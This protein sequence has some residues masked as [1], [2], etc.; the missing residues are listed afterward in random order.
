MA[1]KDDTEPKGKKEKKEKK[2]KK[3]GKSGAKGKATRGDEAVPYS[4]IATHPRARVSVRRAKA[5]TGLIAFGVA[6][7]LSLEASVPVVQAGARAIAAGIAGYL[8]A[9]WFT[10][11]VWRQIMI[12]EQKVAIEEIERR[13]AERHAA[14]LAEAELE[15]AAGG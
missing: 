15:A 14:E 13:R 8:I 10:M 9:W 2:E 11:M 5:W 12:A 7:A 3:G 4:S 6:A 1:K